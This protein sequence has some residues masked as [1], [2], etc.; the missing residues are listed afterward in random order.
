MRAKQFIIESLGGFKVKNNLTYLPLNQWVAQQQPQP[1]TQP[2]VDEAIGLNAPHRRV[3][4]AELQPYL[5]R[6]KNK[7]KDKGDSFT[8]PYIHASSLKYLDN[9]TEIDMESVRQIITKRPTA[10]L[11]QNKKLEHSSGTGEVI[12]N[13]GLPALKG[14]CVDED[15]GEFVLVDTCPGAGACKTYCY[16]QG[17]FYIMFKGSWEKMSQTLNFLLNDPA[18]FE[19]RMT[20][21]IEKIRAEYEAPPAWKIKIRWHDSGDFFSPEYLD[22]AVRMAERFPTI[23]FYAHS[24]M[25]MTQTRQL[26]TNFITKWSEGANPEQRQIIKIH[27][28]T[29]GKPVGKSITVP[30]EMFSGMLV[31][32]AAKQWQWK[33]PEIYEAFKNSLASTYKIDPNSIITYDQMM[34]IPEPEPT[35]TQQQKQSNGEVKEVPVYAPAKWNVIVKPNSDGDNSAARRDVIG[36]YLLYH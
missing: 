34:R 28:Q 24:K 9:G 5:Q 4:D 20:S 14:L 23:L 22:L 26:P 35:S 21:E 12:F 18:G 30:K 32:D 36:T 1:K 27:Q 33:S 11:K 17:G 10:L 7:D 29:T 13:T 6:V 25:S 3:P 31:K 19:E 2:E 16:V 8:K 15:T